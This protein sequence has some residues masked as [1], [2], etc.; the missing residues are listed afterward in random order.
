MIYENKELLCLIISIQKILL[1]YTKMPLNEIN[2]IKEQ[3]A[4]EGAY[5]IENPSVSFI[6]DDEDIVLAD[7]KFEEL[8]IK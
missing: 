7:V 8:E 3:Q 2:K 5:G 6:P 4:T 1:V